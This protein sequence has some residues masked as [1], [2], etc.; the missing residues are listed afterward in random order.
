MVL[1]AVIEAV[2]S[3]GTMGAP[4]GPLYAA[5]MGFGCDLNRFNQI[6]GALEAAGKIRKSGDLYFKV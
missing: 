6:M 3:A 5:L 2:E 1:D 4:A